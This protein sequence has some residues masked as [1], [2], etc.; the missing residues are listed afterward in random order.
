M[1]ALTPREPSN[2][3]DTANDSSGTPHR[4]LRH[5][6][7]RKIRRLLFGPWAPSV[8]LHVPLSAA[9]AKR[10][11]CQWFTAT[12]TAPHNLHPFV[13]SGTCLDS[14]CSHRVAD[15]LCFLLCRASAFSIDSSAL[16]TCCISLICTPIFFGEGISLWIIARV[17]QQNRS[18]APRYAYLVTII[19][20]ILYCPARNNFLDPTRRIPPCT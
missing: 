2:A 4:L 3:D 16:N 15:L 18:V 8:R 10:R 12:A 5:R 11:C 6:R 17:A 20:L 1:T 14:T 13:H 19:C 7:S 9:S